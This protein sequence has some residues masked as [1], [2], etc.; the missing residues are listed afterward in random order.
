MRSQSCDIL[1]IGSGIAGLSFALHCAKHF[2]DKKVV[3]LSKAPLE[4]G[5]TRYAQGGIAAVMD[6]LNDTYD[7]H[8]EDT[9]IA[10]DGLCNPEIV[11]LV[12]KEAPSA[13]LKLMDWGVNFDRNGGCLALGREG[14]HSTNRIL[15][16]KDH[17]GQSVSSS[18]LEQ[19]RNT[20]NIYLSENQFVLQLLHDEEKNSCSGALVKDEE[21]PYTQLAHYVMLA[22]GGAG[23]IYQLTSNPA[24][25]TGD[26]LAL[27]L[28]AGATV[29][30]M[31]FVQ[32]HPT[33]LYEPSAEKPFLISEAV[34]GFGA[35]LR[36]EQGEDFML[37]YDCRGSM[38]TRDIVARAI[39][40]ETQQSG[41]AHVWLDLRHLN[42]EKFE[43]EFPTIAQK[44]N[45]LGIDIRKAM[46]PVVPAAHYFC[47]GVKTDRWA[48]T[49][50]PGLL[51]CGE[52][53]CTGL[54][55]ANRLASNSLLEALVFAHQAFLNLKDSF[56]ENHIPAQTPTS[57]P[58]FSSPNNIGYL[59][60][61][62]QEI[63]T[64]KAGIVR[65]ANSLAE[66]RAEIR[67]MLRD[68]P[69]AG[70][71]VQ[72]NELKNLLQV[73]LAVVEDSLLQ[74]ENRGGFFREDLSITARPV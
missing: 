67:K 25:A 50:I 45:A 18:L 53:A 15:H 21:G 44:V 36:N 41:K 7:K 30:N 16:C 8:I 51:A 17:T 61:R 52:V 22:T 58:Q 11:D 23:Q 9:L 47:G 43:L 64:L 48:Q 72:A 28:E 37:R 46:I 2:T 12:V 27:A 33:V 1:I 32:F 3:V 68:L 10:G 69:F 59:R 71:H 35:V 19:C 4:E 66:A 54:H 14:G 56:T 70:A 34:R 38:A 57:L 20:P 60:M 31:A 55:G 6:R 63:M 40:H 24:V 49:S 5:N 39:F 42:H 73:A 65:N 29:E 26:G 13:M 74:S 62:L